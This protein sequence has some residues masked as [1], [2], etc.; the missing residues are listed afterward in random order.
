VHFV[1][2]TRDRR[3]VYDNTLSGDVSGNEVNAEI[4]R[5]LAELRRHL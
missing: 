3:R 4:D 5:A 2:S 1:A